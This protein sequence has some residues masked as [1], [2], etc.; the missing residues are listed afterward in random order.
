[1]LKLFE[2]SL[3]QNGWAIAYPKEDENDFK[4]ESLFLENKKDIEDMIYEIVEALA[5]NSNKF[6]VNIKVREV[7]K[8]SKK[9][10][11]WKDPA[12]IPMPPVK[13]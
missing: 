3:A 13:E 11:Y 4:L 10:T 2:V 1:M 8:P 9:E 5:I 6:T 7:K 12:P